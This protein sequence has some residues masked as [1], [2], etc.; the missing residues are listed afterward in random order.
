MI[1]ILLWAGVMMAVLVVLLAR[2]SAP[3]PALTDGDN[4]PAM[5]PG[6]LRQL[7]T[8]LMVAMGMQLDKPLGDDRS[9]VAWLDDPLGRTRYLVTF[10]N[11][12]DQETI[13]ATAESLRA[14]GASRGLLITLGEI[15]ADGLAGLDVPLE[16]INAPR[17]REMVARYL[18]ARLPMVDRYRGFG[19]RERPLVPSPA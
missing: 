3:R 8:E 11:S 19:K 15:E 1:A 12:A 5:P 9:L 17:F 2:Y 16:V 13:L 14:E 10:A 6:L 18:P 4:R 7:T